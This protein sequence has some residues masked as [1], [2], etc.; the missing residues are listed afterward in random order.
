LLFDYTSKA[1]KTA[2]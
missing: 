1:V 2:H